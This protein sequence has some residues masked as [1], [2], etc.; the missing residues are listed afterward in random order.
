MEDMKEN[1]YYDLL[2]R[3]WTANYEN[4]PKS[5]T[6]NGFGEYGVP[7]NLNN[8]FSKAIQAG[9]KEHEINIVVSDMI[10]LHRKVPDLR[11][12]A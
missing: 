12:K 5:H 6:R 2:T 1:R 7:V 3:T 4:L 11:S 10:S 8:T 9:Y